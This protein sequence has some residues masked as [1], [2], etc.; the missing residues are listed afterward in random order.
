MNN[1]LY[2]LGYHWDNVDN[3]NYFDMLRGI[4]KTE[5]TK[6]KLTTNFIYRFI[7]KKIAFMF[8][9]GFTIQYY[10]RNNNVDRENNKKLDEFFNLVWDVW[11]NEKKICY[12]IGQCG[13]VC[14]DAYAIVL[15]D[16]FD[17]NGEYDPT[18]EK[19]IK[20]DVIN[21]LYC[22]P[23][24]NPRD[25]EEIIKFEYRYPVYDD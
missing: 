15:V 9:L 5:D 3:T 18:R 10:E 6:K 7:E 4:K 16:E 20:I 8:G 1:W 23:T 12:E 17:E 13:M 24:W 11:N 19:K 22:I 21:P 25:K 2:Y 14:G